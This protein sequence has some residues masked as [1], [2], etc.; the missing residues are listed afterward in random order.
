MPATATA[1]DASAAVR[2]RL[3]HAG[4]QIDVSVNADREGCAEAQVMMT[5]PHPQSRRQQHL[6]RQTLFDTLGNSRA[7]DCVRVSG[8]VMAVLF[9]GGDRHQQDG[10]VARNAP[11]LG[12]RHFVKAHDR[13]LL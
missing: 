13:L 3:E 11:Q 2:E 4:Q 1:P 10:R 8:E 6:L 12:E 9:A 7:E 5:R